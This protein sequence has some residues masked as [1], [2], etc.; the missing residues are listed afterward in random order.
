M[1]QLQ[2]YSGDYLLSALCDQL[3]LLSP[4]TCKQLTPSLQHEWNIMTI[5]VCY[6]VVDTVPQTGLVCVLQGLES[7]S[8]AP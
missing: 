6:T 5:T 2:R 4:Y 7:Y 1:M 3:S 8:V